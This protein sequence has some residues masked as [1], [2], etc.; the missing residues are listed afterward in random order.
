MGPLGAGN[1]T[2][3]LPQPSNPAFIPIAA[4]VGGI[5][6]ATRARFRGEDDDGV[7][8]AAERGAYWGGV[9]G[10][11]IYLAALVAEATVL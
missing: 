8:L 4:T 2:A 7:R 6:N 5:L 3:A 10:I 9:V 11:L 1:P